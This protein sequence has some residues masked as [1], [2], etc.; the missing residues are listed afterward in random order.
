[1]SKELPFD[2][3][4]VTASGS[5]LQ[6]GWQEEE[7]L[8][9]FQVV[10]LLTLMGFVLFFAASY[11]KVEEQKVDKNKFYDFVSRELG[12]ELATPHRTL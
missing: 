12:Q 5:V 3:M 2:P 9:A 8:P 10:M 11:I 7:S 6:A 1:M 4:L